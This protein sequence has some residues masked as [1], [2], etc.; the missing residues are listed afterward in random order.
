MSGFLNQIEIMIKYYP[1]ITIP[2]KTHLA[3]Y[4]N[5]WVEQN[6]ISQITIGNV[7]NLNFLPKP[8]YKIS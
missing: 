5:W 1:K 4:V 8:I 2:L 7:A 6:L 3:S